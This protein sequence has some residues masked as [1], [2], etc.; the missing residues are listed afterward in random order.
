MYLISQVFIYLALALII[1][2]AIGYTIRSCFA[3]TACDD[4]REDLVLANARYASLLES[5]SASETR[6]IMTSANSAT[7][8]NHFAKMDPFTLETELLK[9]A[10][11]RSL[12]ARFG[13]DDLTAIQGIT[14]QIDV[15]LGLN[16]ITRFSQ[17]AS[18]TAEELYWL[19]ENLP[20]NGYSVYRYNWVAQA[21][22]LAR[23][24]Q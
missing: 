22:R 7:P 5:H 19:A 17:I 12:K 10:P 13:A 3:E 8:V 18:L 4:V 15:W 1:G 24:S 9:A 11:G 21:E 2:G 23:E 6:H 16:G 20:Q 14:P